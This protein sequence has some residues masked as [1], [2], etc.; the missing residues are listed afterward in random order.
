MNSHC[1]F[2]NCLLL[3]YFINIIFL[4]YTSNEC[5]LYHNEVFCEYCNVDYNITDICIASAAWIVTMLANRCT[6]WDGLCLAQPINADKRASIRKNE[7]SLL[8]FR[9]YLFSRQCTLLFLLSRPGEVAQ[10]SIVFMHNCV[11]ELGSL[12]VSDLL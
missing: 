10:R 2:M 8:E 9:N 7:A 12:K 5:S 11:Q 6:K 4:F 1:S 3:Y